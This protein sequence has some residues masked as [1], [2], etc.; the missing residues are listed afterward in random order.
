M[1]SVQHLHLVFCTVDEAR[2]TEETLTARKVGEVVS[3]TLGALATALD[4]PKSEQT[5]Y[6]FFSFP[7]CCSFWPLI[8]M[9]RQFYTILLSCLKALDCSKHTFCKFHVL[10]Q[11]GVLKHHPLFSILILK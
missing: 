10:K 5:F 9:E 8:V 7:F 2:K 6:F 11:E 4:Y 3:S 1:H